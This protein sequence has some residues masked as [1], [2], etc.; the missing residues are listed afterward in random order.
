MLAPQRIVELTVPHASPHAAERERER[1]ELKR[2]G[3]RANRGA[4]ASDG[5]TMPAPRG[6]PPWA[7]Q[8]VWSCGAVG[9]RTREERATL[10]P[11]PCPDVGR[12]GAL[13]APPPFDKQ[14]PPPENVNMQCWG[15][16]AAVQGAVYVVWEEYKKEKRERERRGKTRGWEGGKKKRREEGEEK[17]RWTRAPATDAAPS[18]PVPVTDACVAEAGCRREEA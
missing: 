3:E 11:L 18:L 2:S 8:C 5:L 1:G 17:G 16:G 7:C 6:K 15:L 13:R 4:F 14:P 9:H 10:T 12:A